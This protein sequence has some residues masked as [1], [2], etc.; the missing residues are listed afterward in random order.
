MLVKLNHSIIRYDR[1]LI[2][3]YKLQFSCITHGVLYSTNGQYT[4]KTKKIRIKGKK[5]FS[6][7]VG[8]GIL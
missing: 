1:H 6:G 7:S 3:T 2:R 5:Q 8:M 4:T